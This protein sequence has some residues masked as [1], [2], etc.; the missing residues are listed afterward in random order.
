MTGDTRV[1]L[2]V[3][4]DE[5]GW[6]SAGVL[7][8]VLEEVGRR[9][10]R[11]WSVSAFSQSSLENVLRD[12]KIDTWLPRSAAESLLAG[13]WQGPLPDVA[14]VAL[15]APMA[16]AFTN[17]GVSTVFIDTLPYMWTR[18][19]ELP[20]DVDVYCAQRF[21]DER[22]P[23]TS[24]VLR[25]ANLQWV[26]GI[27]GSTPPPAHRR[28]GRSTAM[29]SLGGLSSPFNSKDTV[30]GYLRLV[31]RPLLLALQQSGFSSVLLAG[32]VHEADLD[33][34]DLPRGSVGRR[35]GRRTGRSSWI[36]RRR[37]TCCARRRASPRC[38]SS[39]RSDCPP[40]S[41]RHRT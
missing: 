33:A 27:V 41:C 35:S 39:A 19:D 17:L 21:G 32:A 20:L 6:G 1:R 8:A 14:V 4:G 18:S 36:G 16:K 15:N 7:A 30:R 2:V 38:S 23:G 13:T 34:L 28:A 5:F 25:A 24:P 31:C 10:G 11:T 40:S 22:L 37:R 3:G 26:G 9:F 29:V 12:S